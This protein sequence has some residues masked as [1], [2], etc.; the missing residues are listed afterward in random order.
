VTWPTTLDSLLRY[1]DKAPCGCR[2][3]SEL[4]GDVI[5]VEVS[6]NRMQRCLRHMKTGAVELEAEILSPL[7]GIWDA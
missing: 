1:T 3:R 2:Y 7:V 4:A 6:P 5:S